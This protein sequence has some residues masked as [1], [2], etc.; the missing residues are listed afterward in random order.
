MELMAS[1]FGHVNQLSKFAFPSF[2]VCIFLLFFVG[3]FQTLT[4]L[5]DF[6]QN[7]LSIVITSWIISIII[8]MLQFFHLCQKIYS[9]YNRKSIIEN[10]TIDEKSHLK[11]YLNDNKTSVDYYTTDGVAGGLVIKNILYKS[12]PNYGISHNLSDWVRK[13]LEKEP[14]YLK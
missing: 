11:P 13:I 6:T 14:K 7:N 12:T 8:S 1:F 9:I 2:L 10:L 3:K 5:Y 4:F